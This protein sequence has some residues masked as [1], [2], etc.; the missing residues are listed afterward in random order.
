MTDDKQIEEVLALLHGPMEPLDH[1]LALHMQDGPLGPAIKHPL[2]C[3]LFAPPGF[4]SILNERLR[5][6][7]ESVA[8]AIEDKRWEAAVWLHEKPFRADAL[9]KIAR[10]SILTDR[11]YW[12]L[13][14]AVWTNTE[15]AWECASVWRHLWG[16]SRPMRGNA[17]SEEDHHALR[18]EMGDEL[19]IYRGHDASYADS[20]FG[21]SWTLS[22]DKAVWFAGRFGAAAPSVVK[23]TVNTDDVLA[24]F[25][26]RGEQEIVVFPESVKDM[27]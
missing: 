22:Y 13:V 10:E 16:S 27:Q 2:V 9:A 4:Y 17:M 11:Q 14:G 8:K 5:F 21:L 15:N 20:E 24:F 19:T 1:E 6:K 23:G 26:N 7:K 25:T 18:V 12:E 3:D